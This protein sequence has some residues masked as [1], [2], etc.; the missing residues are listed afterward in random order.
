MA[1]VMDTFA[2]FLLAPECAAGVGKP[3]LDGP[4]AQGPFN[5]INISGVCVCLVRVQDDGRGNYFI[6]FMN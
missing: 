2:S 6:L 5:W 1:D 4:T 3:T